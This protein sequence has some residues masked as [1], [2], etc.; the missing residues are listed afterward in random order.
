MVIPLLLV[1]TDLENPQ[2]VEKK[3]HLRLIKVVY[4]LRGGG[5]VTSALESKVEDLVGRQG[6][7]LAEVTRGNG[8]N[9]TERCNVKPAGVCVCTCVNLESL[10]LLLFTRGSE[11]A[12]Q[13]DD[14]NQPRL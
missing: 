11:S 9:N 1:Y 5:D 10:Y 12:R 6:L 13:Y 3:T 4:M 2:H 14:G 7:L 8:D